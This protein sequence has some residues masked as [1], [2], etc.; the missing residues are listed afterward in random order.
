MSSPLTPISRARQLVL[1]QLTAQ[2]YLLQKVFI[3]FTRV[4]LG[5]VVLDDEEIENV[6]EPEPWTTGLLPTQL[7]HD[8]ASLDTPS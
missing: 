4:E 6:G 1:T 2:D 5:E 8:V 3:L 7:A